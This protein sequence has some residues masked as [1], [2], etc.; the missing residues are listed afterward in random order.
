MPAGLIMLAAPLAFAQDRPPAA[1]S[2]QQRIAALTDAVDR[3][4]TQMQQSERE[5]S[6]LRKQLAELRASAGE[7]TAPPDQG[8]AAADLAGAVSGLR[9]NESMQQTQIATLEQTK[10][11]TASKYPV[12]LSGM[13]LLTGTVNTQR[14]DVAD[15]PSIALGGAGSSASTVRQTVLGLDATGPHVLGARSFADVRFDFDGSGTAAGYSGYSVALLRLRTAHGELDWDHTRAYFALD[16]SL[17]NPGYPSSLIAVAEPALSWSGNLWAWNPQVA[18]SHDLASA[19]GGAVRMQAGLIDIE[20]PPS[21]FATQSNGSY[22]PPSSTELSRWPGVEARLAYERPDE[23]NG[24]RVGVSG[25]FARHRTPYYSQRF[26]TWVVA[27]DFRFPMS[28]HTQVSGSG[29]T[30]SALGGLGG[31]AYKDYAAQLVL[32]DLY[33]RPLDD[34]GG[35]FQWQQKAG[36]RLEFNEAFGVDNVPAHQLRPYAITE[37]V[38]Y[39]NLARNRTI[40]GNVIYRP[41]AS[42]LFSFEYRRVASSYVTA[43]TQ[44]ADIIGLGAGYKF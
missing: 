25:L 15:T 9:E 3:V 24:A 6:D 20:D 23:E 21:L 7:T 31:G 11:E 19:A 26:D 17:L 4:E 27:G 42:L 14:V 30:G 35:W 37:P 2:V 13:I 18:L 32:G 5:L 40:T 38:S 28:R 41:S 29:Y 43:P 10:V 16:R 36:E 34:A 33:L 12:K 44:F 39:Y 1:A 8:Q 22:T